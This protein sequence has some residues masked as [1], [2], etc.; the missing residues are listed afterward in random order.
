MV[1]ILL[2]ASSY[3]FISVYLFTKYNWNINSYAV[4][5]FDGESVLSKVHESFAED[6][7]EALHSREGRGVKHMPALY[8]LG[9]NN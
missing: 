2:P 6:I 9:Y 5:Q 8:E 4:S 1:N 3:R 7:N